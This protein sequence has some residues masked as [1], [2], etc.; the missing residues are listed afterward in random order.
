[1][2]NATCDDGVDN[3]CDGLTD[4]EDAGDCAYDPSCAC[5]NDGV[6]E[7][8]ED[9]TSCPNDCFAGTGAFCGNDVCEAADGEDCV[10]CPEDC[11]GKQTGKP[12][13]RYCCGDGDGQNPV[14]CNDPRCT[15]DGNT[16]TNDPAVPS[17]CG[18]GICEGTEDGY[19]CEVDCGPPPYCGDGNCDPNED[20]CSCPDDC[21]APPAN[22][23]PGA[24]CN[25]GVD[26]DCDGLT[27]CADI[28]DCGTDPA[29]DCLPKGAACTADNECCSNWCHKNKCK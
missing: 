22:E 7:P 17:C 28:V 6:C 8:G 4:C 3:D 15:G 24:T 10:S 16:C 2:P 9:C 21:G 26:N 23:V 19:N 11:N 5:D 14:D 29:C 20:P 27:D 25:D 1:V 13:N 18:D 12:S